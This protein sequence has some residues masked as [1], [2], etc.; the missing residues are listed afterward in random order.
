[1]TQPLPESSELDPQ[2]APLPRNLLDAMRAAGVDPD[3]L[4]RRLGIVPAQLETGLSFVDVDRFMLAGWEALADPAFGLR[5]GSVMRPERFSVVGIAAMASPDLGVALQRKARYNRLIWGDVYEVIRRGDRAWVRIAAATPPRPYSQA[6]IDMELASVLTF[7]RLVTGQ[8]L[9]AR[10]V[11]LRQA[12]PAY[13]AV[14]AEV[15]ACPVRFDADDDSLV[16][17]AKDLDRPLVS[18]NSAIG[19]LLVE[20][21]E[22]RLGQLADP[23]G[24]SLRSRTAQAL[25]RLL[26]GS[27]PTLAAVAGQLCM[28]E[29]TLQRKLAQQDLSFT[30]LLDAVRRE[31]ALLYLR[32]RR[33]TAEEVAFL[34][35]FSTPSSF[36]RAFKRWTGQTPEGWRR[37]AR[38]APA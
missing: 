17:D 28:S 22:T 26:K 6:K 1:M 32:E 8:P 11:T 25:R 16:F 3:A 10:E 29:R 34:L 13:A 31:S 38:P 4:A 21:A 7:A 15:F 37:A 30:D 23:E 2:L 33:V 35:G 36:F 27:E 19:A 14:Y 12:V 9:R 5:A 20:A 18:E 24:D